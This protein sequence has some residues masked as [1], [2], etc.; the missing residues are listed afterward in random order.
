EEKWGVKAASGGMMMP[1]AMPAAAG[2]AAEAKTEF[3]VILKS[4][5]NEHLKVTKD[6]LRITGLG[7]KEEKEM[8]D[9]A[10]K[11]N[12]EDVPKDEAED[13][14][15]KLEAVGAEIEIK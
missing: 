10:H 14:K 8:V 1:M 11:T 2:A 6:D 15:K 3:T 4:A 13:I 5:G 9:G 7:L 12:K